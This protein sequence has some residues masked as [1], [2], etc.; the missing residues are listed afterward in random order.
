MIRKL[1]KAILPER[2]AFELKR[3]IYG[4]NRRKE[5]KLIK[6][7]TSYKNIHKGQRCFILGNGPSMKSFDLG[8]L[9]DEITFTVNQIPR[10]NDYKNLNPNYHFWAD[11][12]FFQIDLEKHIDLELFEIMKKVKDE[13]NNPTVFYKSS[14][15]DMISHP[16]KMLRNPASWRTEPHNGRDC[17]S[18]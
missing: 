7:N 10:R 12:R 11:E 9:H 16:R 3:I 18:G 4:R 17:M 15:Y 8:I 6:S 13:H 14:A 5:K 1:A 2:S